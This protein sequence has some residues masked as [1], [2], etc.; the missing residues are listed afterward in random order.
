MGSETIIVR[1]VLSTRRYP[2][3]PMQ[4][5]EIDAVEVTE[6]GVLGDLPLFY[7]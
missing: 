3:K 5:E 2:I 4:G 6:R 1:S 7:G